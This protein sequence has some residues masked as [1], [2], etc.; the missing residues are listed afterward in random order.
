MCAVGQTCWWTCPR[1]CGTGR[2]DNWQANRLRLSNGD[3]GEAGSVAA[4]RSFPEP[5][6]L[7]A[8]DRF[9]LE[10]MA[11]AVVI[12]SPVFGRRRLV[13]DFRVDYANSA[14]AELAADLAD[15]SLKTGALV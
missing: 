9:W 4:E 6:V 8:G 1:L 13:A 11:D 12:L 7:D 5:G 2:H 15:D 3:Q 14:A 10:A